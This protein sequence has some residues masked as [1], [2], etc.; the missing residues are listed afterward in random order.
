M[1]G[2]GSDARNPSRSIPAR[3]FATLDSMNPPKLFRR[4]AVT[5]EQ[6]GIPYMLTGSFAGS[7]YGMGRSTLDIDLIIV[8]DQEQIVRFFDLLPKNEFYSDS[9]SALEACQRKS[10][11]NAIDE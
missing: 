4:L 6:A 11:F 2:K 9:Q 10:V 8:A 5:L 1:V 7:V 3:T